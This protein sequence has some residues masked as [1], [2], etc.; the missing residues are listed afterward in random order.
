MIKKCPICN[1]SDLKYEGVSDTLEELYLC[2]NCD[3]LVEIYDE[4]E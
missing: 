2:R 3:N 4:S 1:S